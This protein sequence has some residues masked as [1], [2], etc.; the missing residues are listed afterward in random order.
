[1]PF[2]STR[3]KAGALAPQV[4][5]YRAWL[6]ERGY[7]NLTARNM[8]KDL[9]QVGLWL[10]RQGLDAADLDEGRLNQHLAD[11]QKSGRRR[12]AGPRGMVPL[13]TFLREAGVVPALQVPPSPAD[14][15]LEQYQRWMESERGLSASTMLRYGNTA[16][17]FLAEQA[18]TDG[19]FA[20]D[21]LTGADLNAFLLR[22][23][24]RV[25]AGSAKGRVAE[26]RSLMRFL[27]LHG[28]IPMKLG[29]AV[30]PVGGWRFASVPPTMATEDVQRLLDHTPRHG[31]VGVRDYAILMLVARLGLRS[32]EVARLL[33]DDIDW[34]CGEIVVRG[35]GR[36]EDRLPLAADVGEAM[37]AYLSCPRPRLGARHVF[38]TCK[39]PHR[40][41]RAD[42]VGDVV[43]RACRRAGSRKVGP[44]RLRH[45]LAADMLRHGAGLT[46][47][48]QVLRH[49][50]LATTALYAKVDFIA[51]RAVAQPWPGTEAA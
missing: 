5:G 3:R 50:D 25:S 8:L 15:L 23:C 41:I 47:I 24:A 30:P 36:R 32:I 18:M 42:L 13:L 2:G 21:S 11:L 38:L 20:P 44:H 37:V 43:E 4:E 27:H 48:G 35:K 28:V 19:Q 22:E 33:L 14:V 12:V 34:R 26:L 39:A 16:R 9:G 31:T 51:L 6:A 29:G 46:A 45:A 40:P 7:T 49:Q 10:A 1:M 17:R